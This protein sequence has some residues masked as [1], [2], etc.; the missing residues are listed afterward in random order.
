MNKNFNY[1]SSIYDVINDTTFDDNY[2][3]VEYLDDPNE[4]CYDDELS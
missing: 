4:I 1:M 3:G 2:D